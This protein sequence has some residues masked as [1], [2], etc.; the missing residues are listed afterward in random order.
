MKSLRFVLILISSFCFAQQKPYISSLDKTSAAPGETIIISGTGFTSGNMQ[1]NFGAG[2]GT[3]KSSTATTIEV[4]VPTSATFG[5][6]VVLDKSTGKSGVSYQSF[7]PKFYGDGF[8]PT[9]VALQVDTPT[10]M[11]YSYD[12]C[13][14]DLDLDGLA[15]IAVANNTGSSV[16]IFKN[17]STKTS[18]SF[19]RTNILN[20]INTVSTECGDLNGDGKPEIVFTTETATNEFHYFIFKNTSTPGTLSFDRF[21]FSIPKAS[22]G[23]NRKPRKFKIIDIDQDGLNDLVIGNETDNTLLIYRNK[24]T[25]GGNP[26]FDNAILFNVT[27]AANVSAID[28]DDLNNDGYPEIVALAYT[29]AQET[30]HIIRNLSS[31]GNIKLEYALSLGG[32]AARVNIEI[33]DLDGDNFKEIIT[34][35]LV[36]DEISIFHNQTTQGGTLAFSTAATDVSANNPWGLSTGDVD[37]DGMVDIIAASRSNS[38]IV[39]ENTSS[40]GNIKFTAKTIA[41]TR[42]NRN[43][44][45]VDINNDGKP[46]FAFIN[47]SESTAFGNLSVILNRNCVKPSILEKNITFCTGSPFE[48]NATKSAGATFTWSVQSGDA[49]INNNGTDKTSIT[50]N[51]GTSVSIK[52]T[53]VSADGTC[54]TSDVATYTLTGGTPPAAPAISSN[55]T[56]PICAGTSFTLTAPTG[57]DEY[58]WKLP[59]GTETTLTT[60]TFTVNSPDAM[61][62]GIYQLRTQ[63][64]GSCYSEPGNIKV[65][66]SEPP[67]VAIENANE[68]VFC[69]T[70]SV[71]LAVPSLAGF[72]YQWNRDGSPIAL[73]TGTTYTTNES[74]KYS[75]TVTS[76]ASGCKNTGPDLTITAVKLPVSNFTSVTEICQNVATPFTASS[77][78]ESGFTLTYVWDFGDGNSGTG[79]LINHS[80]N[81]AK[82]YSVKLT[83]NYAGL[84]VCSSEKTGTIKV[85]APPSIT[86]S[87]PEG[88]EKCP[89]DS[90]RLEVPQGEK[91]Y[92]WSNGSTTYFTYAK[93][94]D[95]SDFEIINIDLVTTIGC[96]ASASQSIQNFSNSRIHISSGDPEVKVVNDTLKL[97]S[98][99]YTAWLKGT[100]GKTYSWTPSD[101]LDVATGEFVKAF[102]KKQ[103]T[104]I[105]VAGEDALHGCESE[106]SIIIETPGVLPRKSFSPNG[107]GLG[108][109]CWEI[110]NTDNLD[111]CTVY[112]F[113]QRGAKLLEVQSPFEDNCVW[114]GNINNSSSPAPEGVYYFVM[115]CDNSLYNRSGTILLGR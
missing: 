113:D 58:Y 8:D 111:G 82:N 101:I 34:N 80:F 47:N 52:V 108:F 105:T 5:P 87:T 3:I 59:N 40:I 11:Q 39:L 48:L 45:V 106:A 57:F 4:T 63:K 18:V 103:F 99:M 76:T 16:S 22:N 93:T 104:T 71:N 115:K 60:N 55:K 50:V 81:T 21:E 98:G 51:S 44:E 30:M 19:A 12:L 67:I 61:D 13:A 91:S 69:E 92:S 79:N 70:Q 26:T 33:A 32:P 97:L 89:T 14:C 29:N 28:V 73:Q 49:T 31:S 84:S 37:G 9:A 62:G 27:N 112:I 36:D 10:N 90:L 53:L 77:T 65:E 38:I 35:S 85:S 56:N 2:V 24:S 94:K 54:T 110:L 96:E 88:T 43:V 6:I 114:N 17:N 41:T 7:T 46:D 64:T 109:D 107:D 102:P 42:D 20:N 1:V 23:D 72:T 74:G 66:I 75:I 100:N 86:I 15:D 78:G 68:N 25:I 83:T 95:K